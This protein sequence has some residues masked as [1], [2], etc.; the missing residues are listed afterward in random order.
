MNRTLAGQIVNKVLTSARENIKRKGTHAWTENPWSAEDGSFMATDGIRI[1]KLKFNPL[2]VREK[3]GLQVDLDEIVKA[4]VCRR[5]LEKSVENT[6]YKKDYRL[7]AAPD[8]ETVKQKIKSF[9]SSLKK[10][11]PDV[12]YHFENGPYVNPGYLYDI[13]R[14]LPGADWY[15]LPNRLYV[16][17]IAM[18]PDGMA[19]LFPVRPDGKPSAA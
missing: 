13:V 2:G 9:S 14:L 18:S 10:D 15:I 12:L 4:D 8:P 3:L 11:D 6:V 16:P 19:M 17:I 7:A 1:Y 5:K